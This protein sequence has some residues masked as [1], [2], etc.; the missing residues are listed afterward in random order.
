MPLCAN[1]V[2]ARRVTYNF[3]RKN[4]IGRDRSAVDVDHEDGLFI[5]SFSFSSFFSSFFFPTPVPL[6]YSDFT[7][8]IDFMVC[9]G[10]P[11]VKSIV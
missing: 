3:Y 2:D 5:M 11:N 4:L 1:N 7:L 8:L 9:P 10:D 6:I